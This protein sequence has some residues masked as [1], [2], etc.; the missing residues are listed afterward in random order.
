VGGVTFQTPTPFLFQNFWIRVQVRQFLQFENPTPVKTLATIIDP[1]VIYPYLC[2]RNDRTDSCYCQNG[3]VTLDPSPVFHKCLTPGPKEKRR[4]LPEST[5]V[6]QIWSH[7]WYRGRSLVWEV[8]VVDTYAESH[9]IVSAA[10]PG[11]AATDAETDKCRKYN[12]LLDN[13]H[14]QPVAIETTGVYSK[15]TAPFLSCVA[16]KLVDMSGDPREQQWLH[17]RLSLAVVS[18]NAASILAC[19]QVWS[20]FSHL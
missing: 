8:T 16:K 14:F 4:I 15:S 1:T 18:G 3:K 7:L 5:P 20:D 19:L 9:Y 6:I 17:Q 2:L 11:S 13:Y 12:D 10:I